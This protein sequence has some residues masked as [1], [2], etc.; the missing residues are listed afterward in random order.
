MEGFRDG[1]SAPG[2]RPSKG[3]VLQEIIFVPLGC[4]MSGALLGCRSQTPV[5]RLS[6]WVERRAGGARAGGGG[7]G[8]GTKAVFPMGFGGGLAR[9]LL[10]W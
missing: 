1:T 9:S 10:M 7:G 4:R 2:V 8:G 5:V 3:T 6:H